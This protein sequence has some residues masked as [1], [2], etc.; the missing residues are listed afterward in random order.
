[1]HG[2]TITITATLL[3][4]RND[5]GML[6]TYLMVEGEQANAVSTHELHARITSGKRRGFGSVKVEAVIGGSEWS[7]S[8]FPQDD[9]WF[10]PVK[11]AVR[12]AEGL[13]E[14]GEVTAQITLL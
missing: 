1:M 14:G 12:R 3:G 6:A 11:A 8:M 10:L 4:W 13:K 5:A 2:N 7:T 9:G